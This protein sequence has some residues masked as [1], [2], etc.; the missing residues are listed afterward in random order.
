MRAVGRTRM[1]ARAAVPAV[2]AA[3]ALGVGACGSS[4]EDGSGEEITVTHALGATVVDGVPAKIVALGAQWLDTALAL[5]VT[6]VGYLDNIAVTSRHASPW[7]PEGALASATEISTTGNV[8]EQVAALEPDLIL[9]DPFIA[10]Q[11]TYGDLSE[12]AP[13]VP[14]LSASIITPWQDQV[15]TLGGVLGKQGEASRV[16]SGV[17]EKIAAITAAN[18]GLAGKTFV[19][20]WL[21]GPSQLMVLIDPND[22][23]SKV[24][25]DL[26]MTIPQNLQDLPAHQGR[27]TLPPERVEELTADLLLAGYSP[28]MDEQYRRLPGFSDLPAVQKGSAVFLTTQEISA[29]NQPTALSVPYILDKLDP[30]FAAAAQ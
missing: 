22:G 15:T 4:E 30:A 6:P 10:D 16:V 17:D 28:G 8:A 13:T 11:E 26:G 5:G 1:W 3:L 7:H 29:V 27:V 24:F 25:A 14:G 12:I 18:P 23:S 21:A 2:A 9:A 19:S 20:T